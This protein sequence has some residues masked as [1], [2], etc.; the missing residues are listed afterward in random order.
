MR[1]VLLR[2]RKDATRH[3][4]RRY[5]TC[6]VLSPLAGLLAIWAFTAVRVLVLVAELDD[7][8]TGARENAGASAARPALPSTTLLS[9]RP[10]V[11]VSASARGNL[12]PPGVLNQPTPGTD[13]L[14]DR[15]QAASDMGGTAIPGCHWVLLDFAGLTRGVV[16]VAK[17]VLDWETAYASN[18]R[19][20]G[21][22]DPPPENDVGSRR[23]DEVDRW[24]VLYDGAPDNEGHAY[25]PRAVRQYG[26]S[27]GVKLKR[28]LPLHIVHTIEW[29]ETPDGGGGA[30]EA[31]RC[32][33]LRYL[34]VFVREP[35]RGWGVSLWE[36]DVFGR[37]VDG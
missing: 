20:E 16:R 1:N 15:W 11:R 33:T 30:G 9:R 28:R 37:V 12:G 13:W 35:A 7:A 21:R 25:P 22:L 29:T 31:T 8:G 3:R 14:R 17:I 5:W 19:I 26:Q 27:P 4:V 10:E 34:R 18:Y 32:R 23:D 2:L 24:C 36:V 6:C